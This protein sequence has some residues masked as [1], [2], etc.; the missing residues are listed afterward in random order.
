ML[1]IYL[2]LCG[3]GRWLLYEFVLAVVRLFTGVIGMSVLFV[4]V[5]FTVNCFVLF[6]IYL[7]GVWVTGYVWVFADFGLVM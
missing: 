4:I 2:V 3:F 7:V 1:F 5:A 6:A